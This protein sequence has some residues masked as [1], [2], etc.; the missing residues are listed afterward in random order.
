MDGYSG[1]I[2]YVDLAEE[3]ITRQNLPEEYYR[4]YMGG[5]GLGARLLWDLVGK[6]IG[7]LDPLAPANPIVL[8][9]GP[10]TGSP[11]PAVSRLTACTKSPLTGMYTESSV[12]GY[13]GVALKLAGYDGL[14]LTGKAANPCYLL[15][16]GG[17]VLIKAAEAL[18][19][20][21][22]YESCSLLLREVAGEKGVRAAAAIG[23]AGENLVPFA[24]VAHNKGHFLGRTGI[25]AVLG[26]KKLKG[27]AVA[28]NNTLPLHQKDAVYALAKK[29]RGKMKDNIALESLKAYGTNSALDLARF[30]GDVPI[31]NWR[32]GEWDDGLD[33]ING[34]AFDA[35]LTG[36]KTCY[37]CPVSC[38]REVEVASGPYRMDRGPG[39]EYE[40]VASFGTLCLIDNV[41][42]L[43]KINEQC[44]RLGL[45]TISAGG[46][47]AMLLEGLEKDVLPPAVKKDL[48]GLKF[49]DVEGILDLLLKMA[50]QEGIG[51]LLALGSLGL[52]QAVGGTLPELLTTVKGLEA[53]MH[54]PRAG[55]GM[56][57]AYA[58]GYRGACHMSDLTLTLEQ[59]SSFFPS[60]GLKDFY[61]GQESAGK[62]EL[63]M[64]AQD[65]GSIVG[66]AAIFCL[67]GGMGYS[68]E[69]MLQSLNTVTGQDFSLEDL[70]HMGRRIWILKRSLNNLCGCRAKDDNLPPKLLAPLKEGE[71]AGSVPD[72]PQLLQE[73]YQLRRL[74][75]EGKPEASLLAELGL[76]FLT[77]HLYGEDD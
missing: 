53:P 71:A 21:D 55:H 2:L 73:F 36:K 65:L 46:V 11:L 16:A 62:A 66:G 30:T 27:L 22:T 12:G 14:I 33:K 75:P 43:S 41:E 61:Q 57:L 49:G 34:P 70:L 8:M 4:Q 31:N 72:M 10:L 17:E 9:T 76:S 63:V 38:K 7:A 18:W 45:D 67:L 68:E 25:G 48:E 56:A 40:T 15:I 54:D 3:T 37:A 32:V 13:L 52:S 29:V 20:L 6:D 59:G 5:S 69:D 51:K 77:P 64:K 39:P 1:Q 50:R 74:T 58:T 19:G 26:A 24:S 47:V 60:L 42:A 44:N 35:V 23:P 28:G